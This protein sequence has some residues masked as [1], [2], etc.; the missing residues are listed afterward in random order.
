MIALALPP[1]TN[2]LYR[3][4]PGK[5]RVK[6][7]VYLAWIKSAGW[8]LNLQKPK[9]VAGLYR[10]RIRVPKDCPI[11]LDNFKAFSDLL[12]LHRVI[13]ND[14]QAWSFIVERRIDTEAVAEITVEA[15][16]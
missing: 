10:I 7:K 12:Q 15:A 13:E 14:R 11:D 9:A 6:T 3:N 8:D 5:G 2:A 16:Q 1:S 4:V